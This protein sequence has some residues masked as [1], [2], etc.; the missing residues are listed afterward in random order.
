MTQALRSLAAATGHVNHVGKAVFRA[1][2]RPLISLNNAE[3]VTV[4]INHHDASNEVTFE[5]YGTLNRYL[6]KTFTEWS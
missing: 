1:E 4:N 3:A 2:R 5:G 6:V